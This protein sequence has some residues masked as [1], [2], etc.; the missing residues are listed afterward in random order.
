[1]REFLL[2]AAAVVLVGG[3]IPATPLAAQID[4]RNLDEGRP[5]RTE[6]A[7]PVERHAF[8]LVVPYEY[9]N[10][11]AGA[12]IHLT[13]PELA[14]GVLP[15]VQVGGKLPFAVADEAAGSTSGLAGPRLFGLYNFNTE[16]RALPAFALRA[17]V[18]LPLGALAGDEARL[19]LTGIAT[20]SWGR[21]RAHVNGSLGLGPESDAV[22]GIPAWSG[23]LALD[24]TL[25][26]RSLLL[27]GEVAAS[28]AGPGSDVEWTAAL[29]GRM[30]LTPTLV[31]DAGLRR[32]LGAGGPDLGATIGLSHAFALGGLMRPRSPDEGPVTPPRPPRAVESRSEQFYYPGGFNWRFL[33]TYP[34]AARLFNAFDYG[35]AVLYE[36]LLTGGSK[37][38]ETLDREYAYLTQDLLVRPPRFAVAEEAV[39][40]AYAKVAWQA[41]Q[42]FD[43]AHV[44]H[45]QIYDVYADERLDMPARDSLIE[46]LTDHYL[47]REG[48]AFTAVPKSMALMDEQAFSQVFR[49]EYPRFNGLIWS[50]HWLQVGLYEPLIAGA[51]AAE[52]K[53]RLQ[54]TVARFWQMVQTERYPQVMPM[55]SAIAPEFS[56]RHPRA[57]IIFDNLHMMHD[58]ISDVLASPL[59]APERKREEIYRQLAE[60]RDPGSNVIPVEE[61]LKMAEHM[62]G[63]DAMGGPALELLR[64]LPDPAGAPPEHRH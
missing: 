16:S 48:V 52:R 3:S 35:H 50:Y 63:V 31:L 37:T 61:W 15:N 59:V 19:G 30:Q 51:D 49:R 36:T 41:K 5:V 45:R 28:D 33:R 46:R 24:R 54:A 7:Y 1:L 55:T 56:R 6:D 29:G 23:S 10:E 17:D 11:P 2:N 39:E 22:H 64:P 26:R 62:G 9:E 21:T 27:I 60:F 57:A 44:L 13:V 47:S 4:Y 8:E 42:M 34:E 40:P 32:R 14:W 38:A 58:I 12:S 43:W 18:H 53:Q 25:L 20:R